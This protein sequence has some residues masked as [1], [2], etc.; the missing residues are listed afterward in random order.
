MGQLLGPGLVIEV[1]SRTLGHQGGALRCE[2]LQ[3]DPV[4]ELVIAWGFIFLR[5]EESM[6]EEHAGS[7]QICR[8]SAL[9]MEPYRE[10]GLR[11]NELC[12]LIFKS[13]K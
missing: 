12:F 6:P 5:E 13:P 10:P 11:H 2:R 1:L 8:K 3:L 9:E 7:C 4:K